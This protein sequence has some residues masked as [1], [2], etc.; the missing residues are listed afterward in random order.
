MTRFLPL[1]IIVLILVVGCNRVNYEYVYLNNI[2]E[3][4]EN[5]ELGCD[6]G[7]NIMIHNLVLNMT[8]SDSCILITNLS[9]SEFESKCH[10]ECRRLI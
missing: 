4:I 6:L 8:N 10:E 1:L 9:Y 3:L 5:Q 7:C 2:S